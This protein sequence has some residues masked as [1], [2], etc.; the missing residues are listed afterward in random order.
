MGTGPGPCREVLK[1]KFLCI[2]HV[3]WILT[4]TDR[5]AWCWTGRR[6]PGRS[7]GRSPH[8][9]SPNLL[10]SFHPLVNWKY[11]SVIYPVKTFIIFLNFFVKYWENP[12]FFYFN[13][14]YRSFHLQKPHLNFSKI[15][16]H[17]FFYKIFGTFSTKKTHT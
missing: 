6:S 10:D 11:A 14:D 16:N 9:F 8:I 13:F 15:E 7:P 4:F 3:N 2:S 1:S 17:I 12:F 5:E